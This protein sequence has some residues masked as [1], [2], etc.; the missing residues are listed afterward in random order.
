V[1]AAIAVAREIGVTVVGFGGSGGDM[2]TQ[3]DL[4][5]AVPST[6]TAPIQ[7]LH[8]T[9]AHI[10]CELVESDLFPADAAGKP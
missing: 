8:I 1:L 7:Q 10:I 5:L 3:C 9:A 6:E 2:R 4:Y